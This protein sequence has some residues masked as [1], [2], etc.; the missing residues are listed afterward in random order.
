MTRMGLVFVVFLFL[1]AAVPARA[2]WS[3]VKE[4]TGTG[5][6]VM[7]IFDVTG[8]EWRVNW[9]SKSQPDSYG[10]FGVL[11]YTADKKLVGSATA[12]V[13]NSDT[14]YVHEGPG[15]YFVEVTAANV[16]WTVAVADDK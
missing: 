11:V 9:S 16:D 6:K 8:K 2:A 15:R 3:V 4:W 1:A 7:E 5:S 12:R 10:S 13:G 14:T